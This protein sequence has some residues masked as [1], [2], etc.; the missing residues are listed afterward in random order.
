MMSGIYSGRRSKNPL[1]P[2]ELEG[3]LRTWIS[4][5]CLPQSEKK[6]VMEY[7]RLLLVMRSKGVVRLH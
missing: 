3:I 6:W 1:N 7:P 2:M 4:H 5:R